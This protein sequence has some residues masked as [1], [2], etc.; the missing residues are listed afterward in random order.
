[1]SS[2]TSPPD[3]R[4]PRQE[5]GPLLHEATGF[6]AQPVQFAARPGGSPGCLPMLAASDTGEDLTLY[7][8]LDEG[9]V[10]TGRLTRVD[11]TRLRFAD[12]LAT[13]LAAGD[14]FVKFITTR[15]DAYIERTGIDAA[16][17]S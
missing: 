11:G 15:I 9:V 1:M 16:L 5:P 17:G 12:D 14:A 2:L 8:L 4:G 10:I 13:T 6:S 7:T 3:G